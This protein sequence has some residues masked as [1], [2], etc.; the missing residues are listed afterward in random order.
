MKKS[1]FLTGAVALII[2]LSAVLTSCGKTG[3]TTTS[4]TPTPTAPTSDN[5]NDTGYKYGKIQ[6]NG[7]S[8]A[9]CG[10]PVYIAFEKGFFAEAGFDV[11]LISADTETRKIGLNTGDIPVVNGDFQYF[12]SIENGIGAKVVDGLHVGCIKILVPPG[13]PI[14]S[15]QDLKGKTIAVDEIGGTPDQVTRLWLANNGIT[16]LNNAEVTIVAF[17]SG[18]AEVLAA[19]NG[20]VDAIALWDP[21]GTLAEKNDGFTVLFDLATEPGFAGRYCCFLYASEKWVNEKPEQVQ[22]L[23]SAFNK[24]QEWIAA[25][26]EEAVNIIIDSKYSSITDKALATELVK[27]YQ[28]PASHDH[29][30][31]LGNVKDDVL[32][33]TQALID[34]GLL[35]T[36]NAQEFAD[37]VYY[38][39]FA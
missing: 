8:G 37:Y 3:D 18:D 15:V 27:S 39:P 12:P 36:T 28:F 7:K 9:L 30:H 26:P 25:N 38:N 20:E 24:A 34:A 2:A 5:A 35:Q 1:R 10:A 19:Q 33:F 4:P 11:E 23:V 31:P 16:A 22:A 29:A 14:K 13:S 17:G 21:Y 6:I 32:Y